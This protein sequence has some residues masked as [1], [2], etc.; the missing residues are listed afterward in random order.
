MLARSCW[1]DTISSYVFVS[2]VGTSFVS[3]G[4]SHFLPYV[5]PPLSLIWR[6]HRCC[7]VGSLCF[8]VISLPLFIFCCRGPLV[9]LLLLFVHM[10]H[11]TPLCYP[12][13]FTRLGDSYVGCINVGPVLL[14]LYYCVLRAASLSRY[15]MG[16]FGSSNL[17]CSPILLNHP[18]DSCGGCI[19][20]GRVPMLLWCF[21][22]RMGSL[23]WLCHGS[24]GLWH[25]FRMCLPPLWVINCR[26]HWC[27]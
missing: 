2:S 10:P 5:T 16:A 17:F 21:F 11:L 18:G 27:C 24:F 4:L 15:V 14:I 13:L 22:L 7:Y 19:V 23:Y 12:I 1:C 26:K 8:L 25:L 9:K 20:V 6:K 3:S